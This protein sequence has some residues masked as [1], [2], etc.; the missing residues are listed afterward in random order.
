[1]TT[2]F[3]EFKKHVYS[4]KVEKKKKKIKKNLTYVQENLNFFHLEDL[5]KIDFVSGS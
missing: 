2:N 3:L 1:M 4:K 5:L